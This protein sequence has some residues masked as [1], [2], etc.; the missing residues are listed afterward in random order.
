MRLLFV[1]RKDR[2]MSEYKWKDDNDYIENI[3]KFGKE[4]VNMILKIGIV[5]ALIGA[6]VLLIGV[7]LSWIGF[8]LM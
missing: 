3:D 7:I 8:M 5:L 2:G 4:R 1:G 6:V